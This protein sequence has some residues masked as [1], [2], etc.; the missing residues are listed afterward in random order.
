MILFN[1]VSFSDLV[2]HLISAFTH[3]ITLDHIITNNSPYNILILCI[4]SLIRLESYEQSLQM[5]LA[6]S[7]VLLS[8]S[9]FIDLL[10]KKPLDYSL[11]PPCLHLSSRWR[12]ISKHPEW[13][14]FKFMAM[15]VRWIFNTTWNFHRPAWTLLYSSFH[16]SPF[17]SNLLNLVLHL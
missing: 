12:T 13:F 1:I 8:L 14:Y 4:Y 16:I 17:F 11:L 6:S 9:C 2:L 7:S 3:A 15:N 5:L 10:G